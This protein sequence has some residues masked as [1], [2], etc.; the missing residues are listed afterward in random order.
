MEVS[1]LQTNTAMVAVSRL[2]GINTALQTEMMKQ[3]AES[4]EQ[5][6]QLLQELGVGQNIDTH[7]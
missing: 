6:A 5:M 1:P 2:L 3:M 7:A 4:Q